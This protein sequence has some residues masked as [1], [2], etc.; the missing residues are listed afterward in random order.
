M[1]NKG[2]KLSND[3]SLSAELLSD[4]LNGILGISTKKMFG[5][6][7]VFHDGKMFGLVNSKG[8]IYLKSDDSIHAKFGELGSHQHGKMPYFSLPD[9]I[10]N[11]STKLIA[12]AQ[13]SID[14]SK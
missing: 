7:G 10:F 6:F 13:E 2:D 5:G 14:I 4:R 11:D 3:A 1:G 9:L 8:E 12:W